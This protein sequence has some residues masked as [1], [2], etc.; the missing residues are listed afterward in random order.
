[1]IFDLQDI[2]W[3]VH[4]LVLFQVHLQITSKRN[5]G[6]IMVS[7]DESNKSN[8]RKI[9]WWENAPSSWE[10]QQAAYWFQHMWPSRL[11][12]YW[13]CPRWVG[14]SCNCIRINQI[15]STERNWVFKNLKASFGRIVVDI[16]VYFCT[17]I[18]VH[19]RTSDIL[20]SLWHFG[21]TFSQSSQF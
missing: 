9:L 19:M 7:G 3:K 12:Q 8:A 18:C 21:T 1:M 17:S 15:E 16:W 4:L 2:S 14:L 13:S 10:Q 6:P 5:K 20:H 11:W